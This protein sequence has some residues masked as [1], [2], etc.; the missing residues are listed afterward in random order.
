MR[1]DPDV[2]REYLANCGPNTKVYMGADSK[3]FRQKGVWYADYMLV[4]VIHINGRNGCKIFGEVQRER[5]YDTRLGRPANRLMTEVY[6]VAEL[7][8]RLLDTFIELGI[9]VEIHLDL[10]PDETQGSSVVVQQ[11]IGYIKGTCNVTPLVKPEAFAAS[12]AA[13]RFK[14]VVPGYK[15]LVAA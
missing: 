9:D 6:K 2:V 14:E 12:Y 13:D 8:E 1:I 3:R 11:A 5:D 7:Y 15:G 4:V 10:N